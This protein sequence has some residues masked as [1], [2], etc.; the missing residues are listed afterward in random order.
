LAA[1]FNP[2]QEN[3]GPVAYLSRI[4]GE[5]ERLRTGAPDLLSHV[6][7]SA[8]STA[9]GEPDRLLLSVDHW[10]ELYA[11]APSV[12]NEKASKQHTSDVNRF[13]DLLLNATRSDRVTPR[14]RSPR[15]A[16]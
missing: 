4:D 5:G 15:R 9:E 7:N 10:E 16:P 8:L 14:R 2:K 6:I 1:A 13:I 11:Q 3:E 12:N